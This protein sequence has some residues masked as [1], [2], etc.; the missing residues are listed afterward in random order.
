MGLL[1]IFGN[2]KLIDKL[3]KYFN[4]KNITIINENNK[5]SFELFMVESGYSLF[6]YFTLD[7][8]SNELSIVINVIK[9]EEVDYNKVNSFNLKSKFFAAK[10]SNENI[11]YLEYNTIVNADNIKE[12]FMNVIES[13]FSLQEDIDNL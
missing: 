5:Y 7:D 4:E 10:I 1:G 3:L 6:P 11:I 2:K 13:V 12:I 9:K 8:E